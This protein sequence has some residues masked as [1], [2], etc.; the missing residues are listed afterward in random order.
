MWFCKVVVESIFSSSDTD[1]ATSF[2]KDSHFAHTS[3][4]GCAI[5][6]LGVQ[7][8]QIIL[9]ADSFINLACV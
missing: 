2:R 6:M 3:S 7:L 1:E 5:L 9:K 4:L 8:A